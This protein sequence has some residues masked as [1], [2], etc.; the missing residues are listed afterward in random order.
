MLQ[1]SI[2]HLEEAIPL[3][4]EGS[5][6]GT[7]GRP[8]GAKQRG[9]DLGLALDI[10]ACELIDGTTR[11]DPDTQSR[12]PD[13]RRKYSLTGFHVPG[14]ADAQAKE[15]VE[16]GIEVEFASAMKDPRGGH[17]T[18]QQSRGADFESEVSGGK[19]RR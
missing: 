3:G 2:L 9:V 11:F 4:N 17:P 10:Q 8:T 5:V 15:T 14:A 19:T 6:R 18:A 12:C 13:G 16:R 1:R 7:D